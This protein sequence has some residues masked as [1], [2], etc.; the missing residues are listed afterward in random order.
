VEGIH[1]VK[2]LPDILRTVR[3]ISAIWAGSGDLSIELGTGGNMSDPRVEDGVQQILKTCLEFNVPCATIASPD[4]IEQR[5]EQ[6]FRI[7]VTMPVR[8]DPTLK[9][10]RTLAGR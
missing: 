8:V 2:N 3:G 1:G 5:I 4:T 10:G 9:K 6:G 7:I